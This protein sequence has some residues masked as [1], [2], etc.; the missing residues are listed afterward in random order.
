MSHGSAGKQFVAELVQLFHAVCEDSSLESITLKEVF[1]TCLLLLQKSSHTFKPKDRA[2]H[3]ERHLLLWH[4][5]KFEDWLLKVEPFR[6]VSPTF[7]HLCLM[8]K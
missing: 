5:G 7:P 1:V 8:L 2:S 4:E 6:V 3:L